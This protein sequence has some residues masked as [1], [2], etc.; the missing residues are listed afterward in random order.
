MDAKKPIFY[1]NSGDGLNGAH[2]TKA[3][4]SADHFLDIVETLELVMDPEF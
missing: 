1:C 4:E 3:R 2:I